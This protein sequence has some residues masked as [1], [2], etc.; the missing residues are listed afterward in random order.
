MSGREKDKTEPAVDDLDVP[1]AER[2]DL[3][4]GALNAYI[5]KPVGEKQGP[6]KS[7]QGFGKWEITP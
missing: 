3:K 2:E 5:S 7:N 4:G 1:E 6:I